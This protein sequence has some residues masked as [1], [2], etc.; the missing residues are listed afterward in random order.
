MSWSLQ[1][2]VLVLVLSLD[3]LVVVPQLTLSVS[4]EE[5]SMSDDADKQH[6]G[7]NND[8]CCACDAVDDVM[9]MKAMMLDDLRRSVWIV[10]ARV[11]AAWQAVLRLVVGDS[12]LVLDSRASTRWVERTLNAH[13]QPRPNYQVGKIELS[14]L[15]GANFSQSPAP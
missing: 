1:V 7:R 3:V 2:L 13:K 6:D 15:Q 8:G 11:L 4:L 10:P 12:V 9:K 5:S 14:G